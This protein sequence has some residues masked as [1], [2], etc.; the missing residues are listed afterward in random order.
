MPAA[1]DY[2]SK[3]LSPELLLVEVKVR[4]YQAP[5]HVEESDC[6]LVSACQQRSVSM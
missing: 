2:Q 6:E 4:S 5:R 1:R 3:I